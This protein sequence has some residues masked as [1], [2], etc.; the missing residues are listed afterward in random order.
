MD[1]AASLAIGMLDCVLDQGGQHLGQ[2]AAKA[3]QMQIVGRVQL[4]AHL[5]GLQGR[6]QAGHAGYGRQGQGSRAGP[7]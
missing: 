4:A 2:S 6:R 1:L 7:I 5:V 3:Q